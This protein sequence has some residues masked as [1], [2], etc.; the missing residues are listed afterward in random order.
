MVESINKNSGN[1]TLVKIAVDKANE[2]DFEAESQTKLLS[3]ADQ[4]PEGK[5]TFF[6][7]PVTPDL[8]KF[9][10][11]ADPKIDPEADRCYLKTQSSQMKAFNISLD[12]TTINFRR[13]R[14][15]SAEIKVSSSCNIKGSHV[16]LSQPYRNEAACRDFYPILVQIP[17]S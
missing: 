6:S 17:S 5:L 16:L 12:D 3:T 7:S 8:S 9:K 13:R 2:I 1:S 10:L 15:N 14:D 4:S 11:P